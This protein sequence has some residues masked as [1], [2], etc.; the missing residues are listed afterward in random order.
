M[1]TSSGA[2]LPTSRAHPLATVPAKPAEILRQKARLWGSLI[3]LILLSIGFG[4]ADPAFATLQNLQTI[5]NRGA[6][7]LILAVGMTFIILQGS[8][9]LSIEGIMAACSLTFAMLV[10][11]SRTWLDPACSASCSRPAW[12][13]SSGWS[14]ASS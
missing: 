10:V 13:P 2:P 3:A 11:N 14:A 1:V 12:E 8:I 7:P 4:I 5:A 6:I 9:D